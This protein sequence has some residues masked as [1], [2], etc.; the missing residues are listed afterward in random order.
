MIDNLASDSAERVS[1]ERW[2]ASGSRV[3]YDPRTRRVLSRHEGPATQGAL[4]VFHR[5]AGASDYVEGEPTWLTM[6]PG[7]P[8]G[9]YGWAQVDR[10][11]DDRFGPRLY[12]EPI[13]QGDSDKPKGYKYSVVERADLIAA[14]WQH[15]GVRRTVVVTFDY[16]SLSMLE[17]LRRRLED[18]TAAPDIAAVF[19]INGGLFA[20]GHSH[21][22]MTT[23]LLRSR[24]GAL[25][26]RGLQRSAEVFNKTILGAKLYSKSYRP[27]ADELHDLRSAITRRDG[28][29]F[30]HAAAGFLVEHRRNA[31]RWD[32]KAIADAANGSVG[33]YIGG[34]K[35]DPYEPRQLQLARTRVPSAEILTFPGGHFTTHEYPALLAD[36]IRDVAGRHGVAGA[37]DQ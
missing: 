7:F 34:S 19:M 32:L 3:W 18:D 22:W 31:E 29:A 33:I 8:D 1:A 27:S 21:P 13:G 16:T 24:I 9:S 6:L 20:D 35:E 30:M 15:Y 5:V 36:A 2:F 12:V 37:H 17:L 26:V 25:S 4:Q 23:P 28:A 14:M 11:F 10:L